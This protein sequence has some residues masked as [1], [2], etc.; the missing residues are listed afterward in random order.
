MLELRGRKIAVTGATGGLGAELAVQLSAAGA[1]LFLLGRDRSKLDELV[2]RLARRQAA[3]ATGFAADLLDLDQ[4]DRACEQVLQ[5]A[6]HVD[7]LINNAG[8]AVYANVEHIR[9]EDLSQ[10]LQV[11]VIAAVRMTQRLLP[12][13]RKR[14]FGVVVNVSSI[15]GLRALPGSAAYCMSKAALS[16]FSDTLRVETRGTG[17]HVLDVCP[18]LLAS[19][20]SERADPENRRPIPAKPYPLDRAAARIISGM[21]RKKRRVVF[22]LQAWGL[23]AVNRI[24]PALV[25]RILYRLF[26]K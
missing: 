22:P 20:F 2:G 19:S 24:A 16:S 10:T 12:A 18:G 26:V 9:P 8:T 23:N 6:G 13:M 14:G 4:I 17:I 11:N 25:D 7:V 1:E 3:N 5:A 21:R 15:V